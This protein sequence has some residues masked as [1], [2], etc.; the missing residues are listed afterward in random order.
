MIVQK[1]APWEAFQP[2]AELEFMPFRDAGRGYSDFN[3]S[4]QDCLWGIWKAMQHGLLDM[5]EFNVE[6]YEFYEKVENGDWNWITPGFIAFASPVEPQWPKK[7]AAG[8]LCD[9]SSQRIRNEALEA[10]RPIRRYSANCPHRSSIV[11]ITSRHEASSSS[12]ALTTCST[13]SNISWRGASD[14]RSST[15]MTARTQQMRSCASSLI[16]QMKSSRK[17][18]LSQYTCV[19]SAPISSKQQSANQNSLFVSYGIMCS[20]KRALGEQAPSLGH[21]SFGNMVLRLTKQSPLCVLSDQ[22]VSW[23]RNNNTCM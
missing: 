14:T 16:S 21:I 6:D 4:I 11:S 7:V 3:L 22:G 19:F 2:V 18:G 8:M 1:R 23:V 17:A 5:N 10:Q 12:F 13:T 20:A 15:S 9:N